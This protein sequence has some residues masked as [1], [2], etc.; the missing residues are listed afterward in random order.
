M[1]LRDQGRGRRVDFARINQA[2]ARNGPVV[3]QA[4]LPQGRLEGREWVFLSP[5]RPDQRLGSCKAN[6]DTGKGDFAT[7]ERFGDFVGAAAWA[8]GLSQRDAAIR[9]AESLG[10]DPYE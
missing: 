4:L 6:I 8:T 5:R 9:L 1:S 2:A 3:L 10:V 7:G